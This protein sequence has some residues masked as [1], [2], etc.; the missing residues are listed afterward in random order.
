MNAAD[1]NLDALQEARGSLSRYIEYC[2]EEDGK[3]DSEDFRWLLH[4]IASA[5]V[6]I[7]ESLEAVADEADR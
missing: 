2:Y 7:A 1:L 3:G 5:L 4:V 6:S